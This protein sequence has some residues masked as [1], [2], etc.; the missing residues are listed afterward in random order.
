MRTQAT[1][2]WIQENKVTVLDNLIKIKMQWIQA[3]KVTVHLNL[4][5]KEHLR[6]LN[7]NKEIFSQRII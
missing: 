3:N 6:L 2:Y 1:D 7:N 5:H 4:G